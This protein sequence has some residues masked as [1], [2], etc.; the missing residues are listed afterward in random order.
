MPHSRTV[1]TNSGGGRFVSD[2]IPASARKGV[3]RRLLPSPKL[4]SEQ[5]AGLRGVGW[6][7]IFP[8]TYYYSDINFRFVVRITI[9]SPLQRAIASKPTKPRARSPDI[10]LA[11]NQHQKGETNQR[12]VFDSLCCSRPRASLALTPSTLSVTVPVGFSL[13]L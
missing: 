3:R 10:R 13:S 8:K 11:D 2:R 9:K 6:R 12:A 5:P 1:I 4:I 7:V